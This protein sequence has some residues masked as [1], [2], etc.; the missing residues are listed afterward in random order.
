MTIKHLLKLS[1]LLLI[2]S[3]A[4]PKI[5]KIEGKRIDINDD[6]KPD[7]SIENFIKPYR[8]HINATMDSIMRQKPILNLTETIILR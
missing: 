3:C 8:E 7:Q 6:L 5:S 2:F 4:S 1:F